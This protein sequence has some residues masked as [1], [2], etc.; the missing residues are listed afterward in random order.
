ML[1]ALSQGAPVI[2]SDRASLP[3]VGGD[4]ALYIE[5]SSAE[6]ICKAMLDLESDPAGRDRLVQAGRLQAA[7]FSWEKTARATLDFYRRVLG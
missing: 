6:S 3:E 2:C 7:R 5:P 4:A 1:E